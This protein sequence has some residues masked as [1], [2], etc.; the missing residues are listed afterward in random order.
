MELSKL[1]NILVF[2]LKRFS[3]PSMKKIKGKVKYSTLMDM[4]KYSKNGPLES[5]DTTYELFALTVHIGSLNQGHYV[6]YTKRNGKWFLFNDE[7]VEQ[8]KEVEALN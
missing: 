3:F 8:V 5:E 1:P 7:E 2:H 4:Q 6:A